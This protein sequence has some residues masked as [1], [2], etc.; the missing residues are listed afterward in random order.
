LNRFFKLLYL[1]VFTLVS[2]TN[3]VWRKD[4][5]THLQLAEEFSRKGQYRE[6]IDQYDKHMQDRLLRKNRPEWENPYFYLVLIGDLE[7]KEGDPVKALASY[8]LADEKGVDANLVS[9]RFR[10]VAH[11]YEEHDQ[12]EKAVEILNSRREKDP[13]IFDSVLDRLSKEIVRREEEASR[14]R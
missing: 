13:L 2:L 9:D 14:R 5:P 1:G 4:E 3:C 7:L 8:K 10:S 6:A 12:L 11:W